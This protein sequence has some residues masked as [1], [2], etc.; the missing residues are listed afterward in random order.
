MQKEAGSGV[1]E[2]TLR[3]QRVV[4]CMMVSALSQV[5][6]NQKKVI[7]KKF[8]LILAVTLGDILQCVLL[9]MLIPDPK[10][11]ALNLTIFNAI[12]LFIPPV[13]LVLE[14]TT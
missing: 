13:I 3:Q 6:I 7:F 5:L 10:N 1:P 11:S 8:S 14:V 9:M 2:C 12:H 4:M